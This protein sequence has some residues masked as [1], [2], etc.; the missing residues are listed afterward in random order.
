VEE[1]S[2]VNWTGGYCGVVL[3]GLRRCVLYILFMEGTRYVYMM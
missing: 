1:E 3:V 2:E